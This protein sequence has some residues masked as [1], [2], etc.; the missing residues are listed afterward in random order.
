MAV[1]LKKGVDPS[2]YLRA[3]G[4]ILAAQLA[5]LI[6]PAPAADASHAGPHSS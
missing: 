3:V 5:T 4:T 1:E 6:T 2:D